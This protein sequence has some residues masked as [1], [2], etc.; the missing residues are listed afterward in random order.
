MA[1][2]F[3]YETAKEANLVRN[4]EE[5]IKIEDFNKAAKQCFSQAF[6]DSKPFKCFDLVYIFVLL[7]QLIDFGDNPSIT[8]KKYDIISEISWALGEDY[9]YLPRI[10]ND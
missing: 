10:D 3:F 6:D 1:I 4:T 9:R 5:R 2:S 7:N 8:F